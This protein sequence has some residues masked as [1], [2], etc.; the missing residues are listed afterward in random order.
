[1]PFNIPRFPLPTGARTFAY[2]EQDD[3]NRRLDT[4]EETIKE[5]NLSSSEAKG[6][7]KAGMLFVGALNAL[8]LPAVFWLFSSTL[9][10]RDTNIAQEVKIE[11]LQSACL[12]QRQPRTALR[13][14][15]KPKP[16]DTV[17]P[18][19]IDKALPPRVSLGNVE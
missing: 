5:V 9:N 18:A 8:F 2:M 10:C 1:M 12:E 14:E 19:V 11:Q 17:R 13:T 3:L 15:D 7:V 4:L 16:K 6:A